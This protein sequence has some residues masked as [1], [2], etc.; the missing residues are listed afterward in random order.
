M[1]FFLTTEGLDS[2]ADLQALI[3]R[4]YGAQEMDKI[5]GRNFLRVCKKV[6]AI[7]KQL[8]STTEPRIA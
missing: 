8:Q 5:L 6:E 3:D 1:V 7:A 4:G 2:A